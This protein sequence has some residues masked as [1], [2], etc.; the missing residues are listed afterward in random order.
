MCF[1]PTWSPAR[2][3]LLAESER[4]TQMLHILFIFCVDMLR[5]H[6]IAW[7]G[8]VHDLHGGVG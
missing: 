7:G 8:K 4:D 6:V 5:K 3:D 1:V 2:R